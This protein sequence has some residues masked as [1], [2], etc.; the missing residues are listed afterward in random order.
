MNSKSFFIGGIIATL[1]IGGAI[2]WGISGVKES[3]VVDCPTP[4]VEQEGVG[5]LPD[6]GFVAS[7]RYQTFDMF[8]LTATTSAHGFVSGDY[9]YNA[10]TT[11][12]TSTVGGNFV[13][14]LGAKKATVYFSRTG[15]YGNSGTSKFHLEVGRIATSTASAS[16]AAL[17]ES[18]LHWIDYKRL[19]DNVTNTN[20][21]ELTRVQFASL[22]GT[23]TKMYSLDLEHD[24]IKYVRCIVEET[25]DGEHSCVLTV[26]W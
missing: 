11:S 10:T 13:N 7:G 4:T 3:C 21:Q 2:I 20:S 23:S 14:I 15:I 1:I 8:K 22:T 6:D 9:G 16:S 26:L 12:A 19:I 24:V 25:V 18:N 5:G 17:T